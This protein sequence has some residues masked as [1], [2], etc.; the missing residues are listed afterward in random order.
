MM[1]SRKDNLK[2]IIPTFPSSPSPDPWVVLIKI[3]LPILA[4]YTSTTSDIPANYYA[5]SHLGHHKKSN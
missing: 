1:I 5:F 2:F 4:G 3:T